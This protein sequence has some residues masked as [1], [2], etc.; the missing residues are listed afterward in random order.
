VDLVFRRRY[1]GPL[2]AVVLDW[3]GTTVDYG[4]FAPA[5][6]FQEVYRRR[7]VEIT[8]EEAREPMGVHKK[9]HIRL[10]SRMEAVGRRWEQAHGRRPTEQDVEAMYADFVPLQIACL[11]RYADLIPGTLA[12]VGDFRRRGLKIGATTGYSADMMEVL[13]AEAA[14]QGY[15]PDSSVCA[16]QAPAGRPHPWMCFQNAINLQVYPMEALVK[17]GDTLPD[18]AEGLNAGMWTIGLTKTGN[19]MGLTEEQVAALEPEARAARLSRAC[20]RMLEAGAHYVTE[21]IGDVPA[22]LDEISGRLS[23]GERP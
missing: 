22:V 2:R 19:E 17:I 3:A 20:E 11:A 15:A 23:G 14:R 10:V 4:C 16:S 5:V 9:D 8:I 18:I 7:G 1:R 12:A 21:S 6:V 13:H